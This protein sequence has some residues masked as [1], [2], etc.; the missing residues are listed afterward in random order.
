V[1]IA[2]AKEATDVKFYRVEAEA[3]LDVSKKVRPQSYLGCCSVHI[4]SLLICKNIM[5]HH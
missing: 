4:M 3:A 1:F 5:T 2:L